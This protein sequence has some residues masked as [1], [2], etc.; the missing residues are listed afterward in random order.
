MTVSK[1]LKEIDYDLPN[2]FH[3]AI[4]ETLTLNYA[5]NSAD[6]D[7]NLW[8]GDMSAPPG[9]EREARKRARLHLTDLVYFVI[10][11]P[12]PDPE[13]G[14]GPYDGLW[15]DAGDAGEVSDREELKP[16]ADLPPDAFAY[17]FFIDDWN[18][19]MHVA[20]KGASLEWL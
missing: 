2:G 17:W 20:A 5:A 8:V 6:L 9:E 11:P 10:D 12:Y 1:T 16:K 13:Y 18:S 14:Y 4:L 19:F 3:D 15:I 7:L